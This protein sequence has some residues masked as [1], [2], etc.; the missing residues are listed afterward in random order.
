GEPDPARDLARDALRRVSA[1]AVRGRA[2][3]VDIDA[4]GQAMAEVAAVFPQA[5][6]AAGEDPRLP[7]LVRYQLAWRAL[8]VE[9]E[10]AK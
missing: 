9:G 10:M 2:W 6:A 4:A 7:A 5:L 1:P 8:L 3:R